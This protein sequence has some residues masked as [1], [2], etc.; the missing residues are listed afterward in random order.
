MK[1]LL[2]L[3]ILILLSTITAAQDYTGM[4]GADIC[5][6][7][8][9]SKSALLN[10]LNDSPNTPRHSYDVLNYKLNLD[11]YNCFKTSVR[12]FTGTEQITFRVD[13]TLNSIQS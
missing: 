6:H 2:T 1:K 11:I 13:S 3:C 10:P 7:N 8:K 9:S 12:N 5:S 4:T